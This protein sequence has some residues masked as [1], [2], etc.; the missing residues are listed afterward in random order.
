VRKVPALCFM[1]WSRAMV[2]LISL[3]GIVTTMVREMRKAD[4]I[5]LRC[6]GNMGLL[7]CL[8]QL[9]FPG[10][11]KTAK[12]AANWDRKSKQPATYRLQQLLIRNRLVTKNMTGLVYGS[13]PD[14]TGNIKPF[15]TASYS[16]FDRK[17][18]IER[19]LEQ[20]IRLL[21]VG[22]LSAGKQ[23]LLSIKVC[24][25]LNRRGIAAELHMY[26]EGIQRQ[27]LERYIGEMGLANQIFLHGNQPQ[28]VLERAFQQC[29]FLVFLSRSEGWPK[30]VAEAMWWGCIPITTP[31]S[32]VPEMIGY[33][34]RGDLVNGS[35]DDACDI[36]VD[37]QQNPEAYWEKS[38]RAADWARHFT[39]EL[40]ESEIKKVIHG[41]DPANN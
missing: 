21:F 39:T 15:F 7:G 3:P 5:H 38:R 16:Q 28:K 8:A 41:Q 27:Q 9:F 14:R 40:F 36:I 26:G 31:V 17:P 22:M 35:I 30:V 1:S 25:E 18:Y 23:P 29:H 12:Y 20:K 4:H 2:S 19:S 11:T 37:Y 34:E 24:E 33:G 10:K 13:W 32:C 6:P